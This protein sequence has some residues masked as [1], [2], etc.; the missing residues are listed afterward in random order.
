MRAAP[1]PSLWGP[2]GRQPKQVS[3]IFHIRPAKHEPSGGRDGMMHISFQCMHICSFYVHHGLHM[4]L[5]IY[6]QKTYLHT[7]K[8]PLPFML[9]LLLAIQLTSGQLATTQSTKF[10]STILN[11]H[12]C[13][14][15]KEVCTP[16]ALQ[17]CIGLLFKKF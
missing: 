5:S 12:C 6:V 17:T 13:R 10:Y 15:I 2:L 9:A 4:C 7:A 1:P 11:I 8:V 14:M 16:W 3:R